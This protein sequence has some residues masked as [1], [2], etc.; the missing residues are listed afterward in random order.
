MVSVLVLAME[1]EEVGRLEVE[2]RFW[3]LLQF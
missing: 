2:R 3:L 1:D